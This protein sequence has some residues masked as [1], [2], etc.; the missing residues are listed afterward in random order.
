MAEIGGRETTGV[1]R[2]CKRGRAALLVALLNAP[3]TRVSRL[4]T[5]GLRFSLRAAATA[6]PRSAKMTQAASGGRM[7]ALCRAF[8]QLASAHPLYL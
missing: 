3:M 4:P 2:H 7:T 1:R 8:V 6:P 5:P